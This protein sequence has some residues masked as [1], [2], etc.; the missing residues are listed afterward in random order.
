MIETT[1]IYFTSHLLGFLSPSF[2]L[3]LTK[4]WQSTITRDTKNPSS[5]PGAV[6]FPIQLSSKGRVHHI[7][8]FVPKK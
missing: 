7:M 5:H 1:I 6:T 3:S 4:V 8:L 2:V